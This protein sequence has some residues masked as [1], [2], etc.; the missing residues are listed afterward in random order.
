MLRLRTG[1]MFVALLG[2]LA[3]AEVAPAPGAD[4][5]KTA[6][7]ECPE[8]LEVGEG[9]VCGIPPIGEAPEG[10]L[11]QPEGEFE[12]PT[13]DNSDIEAQAAHFLTQEGDG[14]IYVYVNETARVGVRAIDNVGRPV[15]GLRVAFEI[16]EIEGADPSGASINAQFSSTNEF[17][18][19]HMEVTG[20]PRPAFFHLYMQSENST[21]LTY[22]VNVIQRPA[23]ED[24]ADP[25]DPGEPGLVGAG[26]CLNPAGNYSI[27]NQYEPARLLGD[28]P[29]Q[30]LDTIRR[31]LSDPGGLVG[32]LIR[33]R[34]GGIWGSLI[35]G[36]IRPVINYLYEFVVQNYAPEWA[37]WML[38]LV[39][40]IT[41][42]MTELE[43]E[44]TMVLG[45][46]DAD[47]RLQ[48][49]HRWDTLVFHWRAGCQGNDPNCG[50]F[51]IPMQ[52][53]GANVAEAQFNASLVPALGPRSTMTIEAH[54]LQLNLGVAVIWFVQ[55]VIL[56][57][58]FNVNNFG[59]LLEQVLPCDAVGQLA[60][61]YI[62]GSII[63]F[64]VA[65]FVEEA[66]QAGM[67]AAGN[68]LTGL[69]TD[70]LN[71]N[72]FEMAGTCRLNDTDGDR[73]PNTIDDGRWEQGLQGD[74]T[75]TRL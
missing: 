65:P 54:Q 44:G 35:R 67:R 20:G 33:D 74:F 27:K 13:L 6:P 22:Q 75:G 32:D 57:R 64:A 34:I 15:E 60:A 23:G 29:F 28:G 38:V 42:L 41:G 50:R 72:A 71:V 17:G 55:N 16:V 63:G 61:D 53:L 7:T 46:A 11:E 14:K 40:D 8:G 68:Y 21:D 48:G 49:T 25:V 4:P 36:A 18:V 43:I 24:P 62:G 2:V 37:R 1:W 58:R 3:C 70:Q 39:E 56:P 52:Q 12:D 19:A 59:E 31:A 47:C 9:D 5:P 73:S 51:E 66:C 26:Q 30:A 45:T 10:S 69:L